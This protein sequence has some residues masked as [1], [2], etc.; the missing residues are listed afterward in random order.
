MLIDAYFTRFSSAI[1][2][3]SSGGNEPAS[4][5]KVDQV[6]EEAVRRGIVLRSDSMDTC[7]EFDLSGMSLPVARAAVRFLLK[8]AALSAA[9]SKNLCFITGVGRSGRSVGGGTTALREYV[10]EILLLDFDPGLPSIVP[11]LAQGTVEVSHEAL[12][13]WRGKHK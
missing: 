12:S 10:Q 9:E 11:K 8:R 4:C 2:A 1:G 7:S 13:N 6:F 5:D 3:M